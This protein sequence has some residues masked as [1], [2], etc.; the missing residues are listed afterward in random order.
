MTD[1]RILSTELTK[2]L[3]SLWTRY[4]GKRP[5]NAQTEI[6]G[7]V[8]TCVL[9]DAVGDFNK[10]MIAPQTRD[11]VRGADMLTP[12]AYK[13]D[14]VAAVVRVTRQRVASFVSSHDRD[15]DVATE[16]F[17]L[18]PSLS[19]GAPRAARRFGGAYGRPPPR[20]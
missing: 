9:A 6:R 12:A 14:A 19:R 3:T 16:V 2:S 17:T 20:A 15:T 4:A 18:E 7:N 1:F 5:T 11:T 13:R 10:S 8:V